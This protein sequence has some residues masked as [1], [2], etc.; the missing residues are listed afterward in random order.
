M[1]LGSWDRATCLYYGPHRTAE[2]VYKP[3][4]IALAILNY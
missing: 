4:S 1:R 3:L 2:E